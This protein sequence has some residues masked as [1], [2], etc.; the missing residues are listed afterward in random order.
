MDMVSYLLGKSSSSG[1]NKIIED[2]SNENGFYRKYENGDLIQWNKLTVTDQAIDQTYGS[3]YQGTREITFPVPFKDN[4]YIG[5]C[6]VFQSGTGA[7]W[8]CVYE[9]YYNTSMQV[10]GFDVLSRAVGRET[11]IHW[12]ALGKWK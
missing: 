8:G 12:I 10:R 1:G 5:L 7:S 2:G 9:T 6:P 3:L 11:L 4:S